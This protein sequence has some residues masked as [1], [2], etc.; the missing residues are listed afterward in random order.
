MIKSY[1]INVF[2]NHVVRHPSNAGDVFDVFTGAQTKAAPAAAVAATTTAC[3]SKARLSCKQIPSNM[4]HAGSTDLLHA[5]QA[6]PNILA[7]VST[8]P[9][10]QA[11]GL[12]GVTSAQLKVKM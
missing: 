7:A 2:G 1:D 12:L 4:I 9:L 10:A 3:P 11:T 8:G 5:P 6:T